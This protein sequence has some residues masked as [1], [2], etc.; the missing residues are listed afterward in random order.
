MRRHTARNDQLRG[1]PLNDR[2]EIE[3]I[4]ATCWRIPLIILSE[5]ANSAIDMSQPAVLGHDLRKFMQR[6]CTFR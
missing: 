6:P 5:R 3:D 4:Y 2:D 1:D